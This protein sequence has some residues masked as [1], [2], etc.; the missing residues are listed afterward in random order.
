MSE[1]TARAEKFL[2]DH[3][4]TFRAVYVGEDCPTFCEDAAKGNLLVP[5]TFPRK[6]H[7]HGSHWRLTLSGP[8]RGHF[9]VDYWDSY[10]DAKARHDA[11]GSYG[12]FIDAKAWQKARK[13]GQ[14]AKP[15]AYDLLAC[16]TKYDP[17]DFEN[18]CGDFGY[19]TDSRR[20]ETIYQSVVK[21]WRMVSRFFTAEELA[22]VQEIS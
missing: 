12:D 10:R 18:F 21:E 17:Y 9:S 20:A 13:D 14:N 22:E 19:D 16:I 2:T 7:I 6:N 4:L 15:N 5:G 8:N 11:K 3:S 1:Y